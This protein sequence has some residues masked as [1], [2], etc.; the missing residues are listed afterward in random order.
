MVKSKSL[1]IKYRMYLAASLY[2]ATG[3]GLV[4]SILICSAKDE[5]DM[6]KR[7]EKKFY[8]NDKEAAKY[9]GLGLEILDFIPPHWES[10]LPSDI[11]TRFTR[12]KEQYGTMPGEYFC[13][14]DVNYS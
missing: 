7:W 5:K 8:P 1:T 9:F 6:R 11:I 4:I 13:Q 2:A 10:F 12:D 14:L 3:E